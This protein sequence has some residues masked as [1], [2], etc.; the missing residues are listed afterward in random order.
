MFVFINHIDSWKAEKNIKNIKA[1][2]KVFENKTIQI[3]KLP[4]HET[5]IK[6][7]FKKFSKSE[8]KNSFEIIVTTGHIHSSKQYGFTTNRLNGNGLCAKPVIEINREFKSIPQCIC[9]LLENKQDE[10]TTTEITIRS[11]SKSIKIIECNQYHLQ[12]KC[13]RKTIE[14]QFDLRPDQYIPTIDGQVLSQND[15]QLFSESN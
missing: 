14:S 9:N 15:F 4:L 10:N 6:R 7:L 1:N 12:D 13:F 8:A 2:M 3:F 5:N 11:T